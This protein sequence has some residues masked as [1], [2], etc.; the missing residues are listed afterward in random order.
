MSNQIPVAIILSPS[1]APKGDVTGSKR[2][3][4]TG[5]R[6]KCPQ[7]I[8]LFDNRVIFRLL[9][10]ITLLLSVLIFKH[11]IKTNRSS[12]SAILIE[13]DR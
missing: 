6:T 5:H 7:N 1:R 13:Y 8:H 9:F 11:K 12:V 4:E 3:R 2:I 10:F